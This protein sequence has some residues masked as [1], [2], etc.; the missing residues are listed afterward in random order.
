E[1]PL[2]ADGGSLRIDAGLLEG[3]LIEGSSV[4][5]NVSGTGAF[6]IPAL[7]M[8]LD[9][10]PYGCAEQLTS[11]ALPLLYLSELSAA[12]G[13]EEDA[14]AARRVQDAVYRVLSFQSSSGS[15]GLWGP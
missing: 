8:S 12:A 6:D 9:R 14:D 15:F 5:V 11:R 13:M 7:L 1:V 10:Y 4:S 3:H 2:A